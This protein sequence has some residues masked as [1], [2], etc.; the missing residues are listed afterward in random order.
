MGKGAPTTTADQT[1]EEMDTRIAATWG[2]PY[3]D[4]ARKTAEAN[5]RDPTAS[6][7][8]L[9]ADNGQGSLGLSRPSL[10]YEGERVGSSYSKGSY[11]PRGRLNRVSGA[12]VSPVDG[13]LMP[14]EY[15]SSNNDRSVSTVH[16][17]ISLEAIAQERLTLLLQSA[18]VP[19]S[20][21][22][23][24]KNPTKEGSE[25]LNELI[26]NKSVRNSI[27]KLLLFLERS[28]KSG[29]SSVHF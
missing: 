16:D 14:L 20:D 24:Q 22:K 10:S 25:G 15:M 17:S 12:T 28:K 19:L 23:H 21:G 18:L 9:A 13:A 27:Q 26:A 1:G 6:M 2:N 11:D 5:K 4:S 3:L 8:L 7:N 29:G